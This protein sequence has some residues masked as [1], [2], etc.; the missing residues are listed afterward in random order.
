M[1]TSFGPSPTGHPQRV[2]S[3]AQARKGCHLYR[4]CVDLS[5]SEADVTIYAPP[6]EKK[7]RPLQ[8]KETAT[9][10]KHVYPGF[11]INPG[12]G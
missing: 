12:P 4:T 10:V 6:A 9:T 7:S 3:C 5:G 8:K 1:A 2:H 11:L